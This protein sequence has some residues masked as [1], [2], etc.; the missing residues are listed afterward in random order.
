V[1]I[2]LMA[3]DAKQQK[4]FVSLCGMMT[5]AHDGEVLTAA[6][7]ATRML[8]Q[9]KLS[10]ADV[11]SF[12]GKTEADP[13]VKAYAARSARRSAGPTREEHPTVA[14]H[15]SVIDRVLAKGNLG[16]REVDFLR[17]I[18]GRKTITDKQR[19]WFDAIVNKQ[20]RYD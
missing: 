18:R 11:I 2:A 1:G 8:Q 4:L 15:S 7:K 10:W 12:A 9:N 3:I 17:S 6:R 13:I 5:S 20:R 19:N 16:P 14:P